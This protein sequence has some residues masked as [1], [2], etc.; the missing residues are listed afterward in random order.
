M[1]KFGLPTNEFNKP[2][3]PHLNTEVVETNKLQ[4]NLFHPPHLSSMQYSQASQRNSTLNFVY[5]FCITA[6]TKP[7]T[8]DEVYNQS[9]PTNCTVYCG[10]VGGTL[11]GGLTEEILQKTFSPFGTIQEIRVF[12][13]K[14]YAFVR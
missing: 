1:L 9:S 10:G 14:G 7:L 5:S 4:N 13:D 2:S 6:N 8:F 11:A 12:K 3:Q